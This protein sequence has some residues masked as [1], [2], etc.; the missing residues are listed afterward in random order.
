MIC[1]V[2][3]GKAKPYTS[4]YNRVGGGPAAGANA[5]QFYC[6]LCD[7]QLN[8]PTPFRSHMVSK[9]HKYELEYRNSCQ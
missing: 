1:S 2:S 9:A 3:A 6:E 7:K 5:K 4:A 8:G